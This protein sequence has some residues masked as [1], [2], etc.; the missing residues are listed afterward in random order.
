MASSPLQQFLKWESENPDKIFLRQPVNGVW[1]TW[2]WA[3]AGDEARKIAAGFHAMGL[4]RGDHIA[5][6][7]KNCAQWIIADIAIMMAGCVS[8]PIYP[9]LTA[10]S[11]EPIL[12][13]S[14]AKAIILGKLDDY[15]AQQPGIPGGM[16]KIS[17]DA[18]GIRGQYTIEELI[19]KNQRLENVYSWQPKDIL[20]IIYTSGTTG[21]SKG[22]MHTAEA[23]DAVVPLVVGH[24]SMPLQPE[25]I[26]Y[27][28]LSHIAERMAIEMY[29]IYF[30][31]KI[32]FAESIESFADNLRDI[33]PHL[34][35]AVPRIWGKLRETILKKLPQGKLDFLMSVPLVN[36]LI[37]K[38]I[39]QKM[40]LSRASHI[41]SSAAPLS[42]DIQKWFSRIGIHIRQ[43][44]GMTEDCANSHFDLPGDFRYGRVG[45]ALPGL[46]VKI[47]E[48]GELRVKSKS[49]MVGYY[50]EPGLTAE[51]FD[52]EQFLKTGDIGE[53]D[54]DGFLAITGRVKDIFKTDKGK[55]IAPTPIEMKLLSSSKI[56]QSCVVGTGVPQPMALVTLSDAGKIISRDDLIAELS[57]L[58][59][60]VNRDLEVFE[61]LEK[62]VI[63]KDNWS[64]ENN[65]L[66][67]SLK[68]KRNEVEKIHLPRY[69]EWF[70]QKGKIIWE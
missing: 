63:M 55:Y 31:G 28:P 27:L 39:K 43:A 51:A 22:V 46:Q 23:F 32:S 20:T 49:N 45:K 66:T 59:K 52:E 18:F 9:T 14:D 42:P 13:H 10:I 53:Y 36:T 65:L 5:L 54:K 16:I 21:K 67:P 12:V 57:Q 17:V 8:I 33:Q 3:Q 6:L 47:A 61:K 58:L 44:Y 35:F 50:K 48:D 37:K 15:N 2:T 38:N 62:I 7:S 19:D 70:E 60:S 68:V 69:P 64:V 41:Y 56:E 4:Q 1:Q 29:G 30:G 25:L 11:I 40:G 34:F 24:L 26:S